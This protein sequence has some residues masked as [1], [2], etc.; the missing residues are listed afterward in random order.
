MVILGVRRILLFL[1]LLLIPTQLGLHFWPE[2]SIVSGVRSD[3]LSPTLYLIDLVWI[4]WVVTN[5]P[6]SLSTTADL[7]FDKRDY[8]IL[9]IFLGIILI[10]IVL[11]GNWQIA[12]YKWI[13]ILQF[14]ITVKLITNYKLLITNYLKWIIPIWIGVESLLGMAQLVNGGSLQGIWYWLGE[15]RFELTTPGIAQMAVWGRGLV[16]AYGT[17]SHPNSM[18]GFI[19]VAWIFWNKI[20]PPFG[21]P[22]SKKRVLVWIVNWLAILGIMISGSRTVWLL[23]GVFLLYTW[24]KNSGYMMVFGGV[25]LLILSI[26]SQNY[27]LSDFVGGWDS[28]GISKRMDLNWAAVRMIKDNPLF[29]VGAGNFVAELPTYNLGVGKINWWQ[30]VHNIFLLFLSEIGIVGMG[31]IIFIIIK[32]WADTSV[33]PYM[34][35]WGII[36]ITGMVDHYWLTLPQNI[37]LLAVILGLVLGGHT[38]LPVHDIEYRNVEKINNKYGMADRK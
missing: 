14:L 22:S 5:L 2:W 4:L 3:Y 28:E 27:R 7:R 17:F 11:A 8:K 12:I 6:K 30:P 26:V 33:R 10:N 9:F 16:R 32:F 20:S 15:R 31:I 24:R 36:L 25:M 18:A 13:R 19:L 37:W 1:F 38:G 23:L 21:R 29:G 35:I 34:G